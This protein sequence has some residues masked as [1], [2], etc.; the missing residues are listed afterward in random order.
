MIIETLI[1]SLLAMTAGAL[2]G[3]FYG[4]EKTDELFIKKYG[5]DIAAWQGK[6][7]DR[8]FVA[9]QKNGC[10]TLLAFNPDG[11]IDFDYNSITKKHGE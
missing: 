10:T 1:L 6:S 2:I 9:A 8:Y 3:Y 5:W 11:S 4:K 7:I